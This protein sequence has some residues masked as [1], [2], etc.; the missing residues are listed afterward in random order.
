MHVASDTS[1]SFDAA[2]VRVHKGGS[3]IG[4]GKAWGVALLVREML[5]A[6]ARQ[7]PP[8]LEGRDGQCETAL[9]VR[10]ARGY[11]NAPGPA[12]HSMH[13]SV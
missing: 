3:G 11:I 4:I 12:L 5:C 13:I 9:P 1:T 8:A 10:Q 6:N 2:S 7:R